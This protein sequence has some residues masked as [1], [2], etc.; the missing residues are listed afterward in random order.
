M[1]ISK[2]EIWNMFI[3]KLE[4][5]EIGE[6]HCLTSKCR[7][8]NPKIH[9]LSWSTKPVPRAFLFP[10]LLADLDEKYGNEIEMDQK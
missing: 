5:P 1:F 2:Y 8:I 6:N 10:L 7:F 3:S 4:C 9:E